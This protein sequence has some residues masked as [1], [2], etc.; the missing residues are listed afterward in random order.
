[1]LS[2]YMDI[3]VNEL[4]YRAAGINHICW[5]LELTHRGRDAYP[6]LFEAMNDPLTYS[7]DRVHFEIMRHFGRFK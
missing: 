2:N 3:P 7:S 1:M 6:L 5:F 4:R